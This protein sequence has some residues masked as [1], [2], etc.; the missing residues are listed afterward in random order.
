MKNGKEHAEPLGQISEQLARIE[1][2]A[3]TLYQ[4]NEDEVNG[5]IA[6]VVEAFRGM[7]ASLQEYKR[8]LDRIEERQATILERARRLGEQNDETLHNQREMLALLKQTRQREQ[9]L[10]AGNGKN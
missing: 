2:T 3:S 1:R 7:R 6:Q 10:G 4:F 5:T 9:S 8:Q